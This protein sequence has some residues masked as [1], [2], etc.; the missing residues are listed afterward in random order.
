M[1]KLIENIDLFISNLKKYTL[2]EP[3]TK[4]TKLKMIAIIHLGIFHA[5][6]YLGHTEQIHYAVKH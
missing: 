5:D 1:I 6:Q 2:I 4:Y 3:Y